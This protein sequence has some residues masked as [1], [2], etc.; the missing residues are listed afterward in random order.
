MHGGQCLPRP[1]NQPGRN[2]DLSVAEGDFE[3]C[4]NEPVS[5]M[6]DIASLGKSMGL[7]VDDDD[8]GEL[9]EDCSTELTTK[10]LQDLEREQQQTTAEELCSEERGGKEGGYSYFTNLG[11][12]WEIR[13]NAKVY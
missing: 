12:A 11:N 7:E 1:C 10:E 5:A 13:R 3:G 9:G 4:E 8:L 6:E 2:C